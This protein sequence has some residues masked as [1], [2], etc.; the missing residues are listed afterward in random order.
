MNGI[1]QGLQ[2]EYFNDGVIKEE[3]MCDNGLIDGIK[4]IYYSTGHYAYSE[5]YEKGI[6][7]GYV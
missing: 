5:L 3:Y 2:F 7:K 6:L 1:Q 4:K